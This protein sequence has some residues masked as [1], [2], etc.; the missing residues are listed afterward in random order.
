VT[1]E[2]VGTHLIVWLLLQCSAAG[3]A[4]QAG[5][6]RELEV[7]LGAVEGSGTGVLVRMCFVW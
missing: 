5:L 4:M 3:M 7:A 6:E 2:L 1:G